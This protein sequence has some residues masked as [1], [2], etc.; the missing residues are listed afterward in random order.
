MGDGGF[1]IVVKGIGQ[2][3]R[4]RFGRR[5]RIDQTDIVVEYRFVLRRTILTPVAGQF[6][7]MVKNPSSFEEVTE[8]VETV[9]I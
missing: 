1:G 5:S 3:Q 9:I 6:V 2:E 7:I 8:L 4:L